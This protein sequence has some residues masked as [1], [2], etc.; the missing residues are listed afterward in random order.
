MTKAKHM[1]SVSELVHLHTKCMIELILLFLPL[2]PR[3]VSVRLQKMGGTIPNSLHDVR[4]NTQG[5]KAIYFL[6]E[7]RLSRKDP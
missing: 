5:R 6:A 7:S 3:F 4:R 2:L 1:I